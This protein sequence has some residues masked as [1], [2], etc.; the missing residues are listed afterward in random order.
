MEV[1]DSPTSMPVGIPGESTD[2]FFEE[3]NA[4]D[5]ITDLGGSFE[6]L[7]SCNVTRPSAQEAITPF[8]F[9]PAA[10]RS[11]FMHED[12]QDSVKY[13]DKGSTPTMQESAKFEKVSRAVPPG[14]VSEALRL[15]DKRPLLYPWEK[16]R[17]GRIFGEQGRLNLKRPKL[18]PC[19]QL[20][21]SRGCSL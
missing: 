17:L 21:S 9:P 1:D 18:H 13:V 14:I 4:V 16:G 7:A 11:L 15:T 19:Q 6:P 20:C 2:D 12:A 10:P 8:A 3:F 5:P